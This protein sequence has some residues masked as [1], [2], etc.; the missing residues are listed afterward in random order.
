M[1]S[2]KTRPL[3]S[4]EGKS[5]AAEFGV[6]FLGELPIDY[7]ASKAAD[8]GDM[9]SLLKTNFARALLSSLEKSNL[10]NDMELT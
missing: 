9:Q 7:E 2:S 1:A 4:S 6:K 3:Q 5:L 8:A 10:I